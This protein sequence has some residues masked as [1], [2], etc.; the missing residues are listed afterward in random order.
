ME[1]QKTDTAPL[2]GANAKPRPLGVDSLLIAASIIIREK[3]SSISDGT[4]TKDILS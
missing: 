1:Y 4:I 3:P 2:W